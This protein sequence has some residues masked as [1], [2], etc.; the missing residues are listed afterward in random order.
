MYATR[1]MQRSYPAVNPE[2]SNHGWPGMKCALLQQYG[3]NE[4]LSVWVEIL[5]Y[6]T[7]LRPNL[8]LARSW[9]LGE[10]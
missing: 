9:A 2:S 10:N 3:S 1:N 8:W 6:K 4:A 7:K 5:H